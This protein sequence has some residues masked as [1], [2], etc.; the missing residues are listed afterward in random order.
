MSRRRS[1]VGKVRRVGGVGGLS[2]LGSGVVVDFFSVVEVRV[3]RFWMADA[4]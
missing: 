3:C 1:S 4:S 2:S